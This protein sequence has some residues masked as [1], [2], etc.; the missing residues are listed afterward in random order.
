MYANS[1]PALSLVTFMQK[2]I[3]G[4]DCGNASIKLFHGPCSLSIPSYVYQLPEPLA[5]DDVP[6]KGYVEYLSGAATE[7]EGKA[8]LVGSEVV[9]RYPKAYEA[10]ASTGKLTLGLQCLLGAL[11]HVAPYSQHLKLVAS[12]HMRELTDELAGSLNGVH[13]VRLGTEPCVIEIEVLRAL[14]EGAG[15][16]AWLGLQRGVNALLDLGGG[17]SEVHIY[18]NG[19]RLPEASE[20]LK[21]GVGDLV[22]AIAQSGELRAAVSDVIQPHH[23][24]TAIEQGTFRYG[25]VSFQGIY[26]KALASWLPG[27]L[28]PLLAKVEPYRLQQPRVFAVGGGALLPGVRELLAK[29]GIE[30][31]VDAVMLNAKGQKAIAEKLAA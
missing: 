13:R 7:L 6:D 8:F 15:A 22:A 10:V 9:A 2:T 16:A 17:T 30:I 19:K 29:R 21:A 1:M 5:P 11:S 4:L 20:Q 25:D 3:A 14:P 27:V 18:S 23:V 12:I 24:R 31:P 28:K 26:E